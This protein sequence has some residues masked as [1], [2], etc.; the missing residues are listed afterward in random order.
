V[1]VTQGKQLGPIT[2][3]ADCYME[4]GYI[5][6]R[7]KNGTYSTVMVGQNFTIHSTSMHDSGSYVCYVTHKNDTS[8]IGTITMEIS[9]QGMFNICIALDKTSLSPPI[10]FFL[11]VNTKPGKSMV[12]YMYVRIYILSLSM[13][14]IFDFVPKV[15]KFSFSFYC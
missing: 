12:V 2:C 6:E 8:S 3:S 10:F 14:L 5:W 4:C 15:W 11:S 1:S 13:I 7:F 9:V